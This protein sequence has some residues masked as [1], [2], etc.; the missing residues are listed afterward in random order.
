MDYIEAQIRI[1]TVPGPSAVIQSLCS[2][3]FRP[4][5]KCVL[6]Y[7]NWG[8][9]TDDMWDTFQHAHRTRYDMTYSHV[10]W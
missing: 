1:L 4:T 10:H 3:L 9:T 5:D 2:I 6:T 8:I 7:P